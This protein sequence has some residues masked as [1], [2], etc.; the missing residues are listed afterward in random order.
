MSNGIIEVLN[1]IGGVL[2]FGVSPLYSNSIIQ[3]LAAAFAGSGSA[4]ILVIHFS[5][6]IRELPLFF[7]RNHLILC[8]VHPTTETLV[9]Q[10]RNEKTKTVVIGAEQKTFETEN[11]RRACT[12]M[13]SGDP[14]NPAMLS[15][16]RLKR[17]RALLALTD[18]DSINA[19]IALSAMK[20]LE[21]RKV[22]QL[23]CILQINNPGLWRIIREEALSQAKSA[24]VRLDF[25][26]GPAAGAR[27]LVNTYFTP[28]IRAWSEN[29]SL[30]I[31]VGGG[32]LGENI[33]A[34]ASYE[35]F[36]N[37]LAPS[38]LHIALI[39][40]HAD[41]VKN[42]ML[43][44]YP[45]LRDV[46]NID[47]I[48]I[49]VE[50]AE[51]QKA[52]FLRDRGSFSSV[53]VFVCLNDDTASL[54]AALALSHHLIG[55]NARILVRM[56][57]NAGLA[58]LIEERSFETIQVIPFNSLSLAARSELVLGGIREILARGIHDQYLATWSLQEPA[59]GDSAAVPWNDLPE[60]LKESN[61][62]QA[63]G[64]LEKLRAVGCDIV[65]MTDWTASSFTFTTD[66]IEYLAEMEHVRWMDVM[67]RQGFTF[68][69]TKDEERKTHP[70]MVQYSELNEPEKEKDRD[71]VRMIPHYLALIDFQVYRPDS[72]NSRAPKSNIED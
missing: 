51:F 50:S 22:H 42:R 23:T 70:C 57:H 16:A 65:P 45:Q 6:K 41:T 68:G 11:I 71:S 63:D 14:K 31:V 33:I 59:K 43:S 32:R 13:L 4:G 56:D 9:Q 58:R 35:W 37:G 28:D 66:E 67:K 10:F 1:A 20:I 5:E 19:E 54:T 26:N 40:L 72:C 24:A 29:P 8:G 7:C 27:L 60:R 2:R 44:T 18:S 38:V 21:K 52:G 53:L 61:R 55:L 12:A 30:F 3:I 48:P 64:I 34:R 39:D 15:H 69:A 47:A 62:L 36:Q 17:A 46:A 49:D 25:Y